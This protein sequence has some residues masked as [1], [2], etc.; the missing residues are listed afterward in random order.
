MAAVA[1]QVPAELERLLEFVKG[2]RLILEIGTALGGTLLAILKQADPRAE[3]ISIDL[4]GG[5]FGGELEPPA[6]SEMQS[7][8]LPGQVLHVIRADSRAAKTVSMVK[9][10]LAGRKFDFVLID[11]DHAYEGVKDDFE[12]YRPMASDIIAFHDIAHHADPAI[13][14]ER[15]WNELIGDKTEIIENPEQGWAGIGI[16]KCHRSKLIDYGY[17]LLNQLKHPISTVNGWLERYFIRLHGRGEPHQELIYRCTNCHN[18]ITWNK[19]RSGKT[20]C[21]GKITP[22]NVGM[23]ELCKLL[24]IPWAT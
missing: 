5:P 19:I 11:G 7:W 4:P 18:L 15:F 13:G 8:R 22:T 1:L 21:N 3:I 16:F 14:V 20:C 2:K 17:F 24:L 12:I 23:W 9:E 10:I 6:V